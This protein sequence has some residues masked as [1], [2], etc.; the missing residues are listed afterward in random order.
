[1]NKKNIFL[2][3][4]GLILLILLMS[5]VSAGLC[6]GSDG[7][8]HDCDGFSDSYY[9]YNF[10]PNYETEY[11]KETAES[12]SSI[13]SIKEGRWGYEKTSSSSYEYT[14]S[15]TYKITRDYS[16]PRTRYDDYRR[17]RYDYYDHYEK[18][19]SPV[20]IFINNPRP[21]STLYTIHVDKSYWRYKE[22][23]NPEKY[24]DAKYYEY[25]YKP[26]YSYELQQY[27]WRW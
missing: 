23:Y 4:E 9:R 13:E 26:R 7:Y 8:Y 3:F 6:R 1:M 17:K 25:Y 27:N 10:Y 12:S 21:K 11:H 24:K 22:P 19:K 5:F 2:I 14:D 18:D 20:V 16:R 15:E